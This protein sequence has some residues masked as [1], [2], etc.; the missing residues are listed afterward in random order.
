MCSPGRKFG[1]RRGLGGPDRA[2]AAH[3][4]PLFEHGAAGDVGGPVLLDR[5]E[6]VR[7]QEVVDAAAD[8]VA[9]RDPDV[10]A[11][12]RVHVDVPA[13]VVGDEDR[14]ERGVEDGA[15]L[16]LVLAQ[17]ELG[18]FPLD[19]R[20]DQARRG[21]ESVRLGRAPF[22]LRDAVV[23]P[24]EAPPVAEH[25]DRHGHERPDPLRLEQLVGFC[26]QVGDVRHE[27]LVPRR[28][29]CE[30]RQADLV[31][32]HVLHRLVGELRGDAGRDPLEALGTRQP[33]VGA[34]AGLEEVRT[35]GLRCLAELAEE[36]RCGSAPGRLRN[37][38]LG[39]VAD[40]LED[41]VAAAQIAFGLRALFASARVGEDD[42]EL[43]G[44]VDEERHLVLAPETRLGA[45]EPED[46][47]ELAVAED[48]HV[49][50]RRDASFEQPVPDR[51][52]PGCR[53]H[54]LEDDRRSGFEARD[55]VGAPLDFIPE[56]G[57]PGIGRVTDVEAACFTTLDV[58]DVD[59]PEE[60][61]QAL[62][63]VGDDLVGR[64]LVG[65][66]REDAD[67]ELEAHPVLLVRRDVLEK[68]LGGAVD[69]D[70]VVADPDDAPVAG[71]QAVVGLGRRDALAVA[72]RDVFEHARRG[73]RDGC[74]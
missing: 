56:L 12:R 58:A 49:H 2:V 20:L 67:Q 68:A 69:H 70:L 5:R 29:L 41:R 15:Q 18:A 44:D 6:P 7:R 45:V 72:Q 11:R 16:L 60:V 25:E 14:V 13:V 39:C 40:R 51:I 37:E 34:D 63:G 52:E 35:A 43:A 22:S 32:A 61:S 42:C 46:A 62:G 65:G 26:R 50:E 71:D 23:E 8:Q 53:A 24:D 21:P 17:D 57:L 4:L 28:T 54:V 73:P 31:E 30:F 33:A 64:R 10:V 74:S 48:R 36:R 19:R 47:L 38:P 66:E 27:D 59:V 55:V 1:L 9:L 3:R